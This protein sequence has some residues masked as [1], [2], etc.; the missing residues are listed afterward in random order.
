[1]A[2]RDVPDG[3]LAVA[4]ARQQNVEGWAERKKKSKTDVCV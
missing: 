1:V 2:N 3:A 4:R